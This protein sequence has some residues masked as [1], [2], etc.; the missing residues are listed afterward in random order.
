VSRVT[1]AEIPYDAP[2]Y[3]ASAHPNLWTSVD[4]SRASSTSASST[5]ACHLVPMGIVPTHPV[6]VADGTAFRHG[7]TGGPD[8]DAPSDVGAP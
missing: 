6:T 7:T 2:Q 1:R 3:P 8:S 4:S 5:T